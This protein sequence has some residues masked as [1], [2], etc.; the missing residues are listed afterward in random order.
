MEEVA[1]WLVA[2]VLAAIGTVIM[3]VAW[4]ERRQRRRVEALGRRKKERIRL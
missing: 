3:G 2:L 1:L 4:F